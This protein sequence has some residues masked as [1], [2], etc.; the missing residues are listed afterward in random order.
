MSR[1]KQSS[2]DGADPYTRQ[3]YLFWRKHKKRFSQRVKDYYDN[4]LRNMVKNERRT[5][6]LNE[7]AI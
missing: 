5:Y 1:Q 7:S 6:R 4:W 3:P 2:G